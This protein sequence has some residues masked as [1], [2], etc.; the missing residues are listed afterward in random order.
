[1]AFLRKNNLKEKDKNSQEDIINKIV[2]NN[3]KKMQE[4]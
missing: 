3:I 4:E 1:L 2:E